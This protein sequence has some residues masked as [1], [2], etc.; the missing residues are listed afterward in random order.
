MSLWRLRREEAKIYGQANT[1]CVGTGWNDYTAKPNQKTTEILQEALSSS[2]MHSTRDSYT[3]DH[4]ASIG[5]KSLMTSCATT[6]NLTEARCAAIPKRRSSQAIF[7]LSAWRP[8]LAA[9]RAFVESIQRHYQKVYFFPQMQEDWAYFS[10]FGWSNIRMV[11]P[12]TEAYNTF[13]ENEDVDF[14]GTRLHGGIRALQKG[15]RALI[16]SIDNRA[17]ELGKDTGLPVLARDATKEIEH[18]IEAG[19]PTKVSLPVDDIDAWKSQFR[20][21][22]LK[23]GLSVTPR[24]GDERS[25]LLRDAART[26]RRALSG[27]A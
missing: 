1:I 15:R 4:L 21:R 18:W 17:R 7:T 11:G 27:N 12:T 2:Y 16:L 23:H 22:E 10:S 13:L 3:R 9:D 25:L 14:I 8:N 20:N 26:F 19:H 24:S 6:W 5:V